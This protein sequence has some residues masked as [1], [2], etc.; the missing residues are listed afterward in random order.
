MLAGRHD[1]TFLSSS[2]VPV[3]TGER[4]MMR[5]DDGVNDGGDAAMSG[6]PEKGGC[7]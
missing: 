4:A 6:V 5:D 3:H 2:F 1:E 7:R